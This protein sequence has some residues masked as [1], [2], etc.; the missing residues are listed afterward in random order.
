M[1]PMR[2]RVVVRE[3]KERSSLVIDPGRWNE[4][5]VTTHRGVVL[6]V[7]AP[8]RTESGAEVPHGFKPGDVVR[9]HFEATEKG[10]IAPWED[11]EPALWMAQRE[12]DGVEE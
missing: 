10:R 9:F 8:V 3:L 4:R 5:E 12:I 6:A 2:G 1:T 11:G 7:G